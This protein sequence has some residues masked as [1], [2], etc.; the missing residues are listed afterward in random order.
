MK[1]IGRL[2]WGP[3]S[4]ESGLFFAAKSCF[5]NLMI[6]PGWS[7]FFTELL[8]EFSIKSKCVCL[9]GFGL[10]APVIP[11]QDYGI[12]VLRRWRA[13]LEVQQRWRLALLMLSR[14]PLFMAT[15]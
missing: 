2:I 5:M 7:C 10:Y 1:I 3:G 6:F 11:I 13:Q 8:V 14:K 15:G 4:L 9:K 12:I